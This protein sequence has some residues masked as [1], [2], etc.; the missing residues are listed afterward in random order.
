[1]NTFDLIY[2][3]PYCNQSSDTSDIKDGD[4]VKGGATILGNIWGI[5]LDGIDLIYLILPHM[6]I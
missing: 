3:Q 4:D 5:S 1:M 2:R 6:L